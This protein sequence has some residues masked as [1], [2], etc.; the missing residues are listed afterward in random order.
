MPGVELFVSRFSAGL[1]A[2][3]LLLPRPCL[4]GIA[5]RKGYFLEQLERD[6]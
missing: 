3:N 5:D 4:F 1:Y 2:T 6:S